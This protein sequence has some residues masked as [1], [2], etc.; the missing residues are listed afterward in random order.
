M[1]IVYG[2]GLILLAVMLKIL[3]FAPV[4]RIQLH[5]TEAATFVSEQKALKERVA[6]LAASGLPQAPATVSK[7]DVE[8][9][10]GYY[11]LL[12]GDQQSGAVK[13]L[14]FVVGRES[15]QSESLKGWIPFEVT[16]ECDFVTSVE[17]FSVLERRR[18][19]VR[20][21]DVNIKAVEARAG[22]IRCTV[23][24]YLVASA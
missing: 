23:R 3:V 10:L 6:R 1:A 9:T 22:T 20:I 21:V 19:R 2:A 16:L 17:Y 7:P 15:K 8:S 11:E 24:G 5:S 18:S 4:D 13:F 14:N 12:S